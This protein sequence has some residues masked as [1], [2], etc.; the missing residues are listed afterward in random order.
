[1]APLLNL[2]AGALRRLAGGQWSPEAVAEIEGLAQFNT[3]YGDMTVNAYLAW[4]PASRD[5]VAFDTGADCG[6][7]LERIA[8]EKLTVKLILLTHAHPDH[9]ADLLRLRKE[10]GAP[11]H[12]S[13]REMAEGEPTRKEKVSRGSLK[14]GAPD[15][16]QLAG[17]ITFVETIRRP[18][19]RW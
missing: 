9:V 17:G 6:E 10:T 7:M 14:T 4:D 2:D 15:L 1:M 19:D 8:A 5:A 18:S 16:G 12:I 11:V 13:E 3:I